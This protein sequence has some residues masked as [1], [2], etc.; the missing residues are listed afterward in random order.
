MPRST[1]GADGPRCP[2]RARHRGEARTIADAYRCG[3]PTAPTTPGG[4]SRRGAHPPLRH[5]G[6][7]RQILAFVTLNA[8][9]L[10][11]AA[12]LLVVL[13]HVMGRR[14]QIGALRAFGAPRAVV[15]AV[16]WLEAVL[17]IGAGLAGG[18]RARL[19]R[20]PNAGAADLDA[21]RRVLPV[22]FAAEDGAAFLLLF[23]IGGLAA[24]LPAMLAYRQSPAAAFAPDARCGA[25]WS[26][27]GDSPRIAWRRAFRPSAAPRWNNARR[28][29]FKIGRLYRECLG[30]EEIWWSQAESNRRPLECI[31]ALSQLSNGPPR[32]PDAWSAGALHLGFSSGLSGPDRSGTGRS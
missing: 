11:A 28:R 14:R 26:G 13:I 15:C 20:R 6:D 18:I 16:V 29:P 9:L 1:G 21:D 27:A 24:L 23:A 30:D 32:A 7:A 2:G 12:V 19:W 31:Q 3:R 10:V 17:V 8:Q 5:V 25:A 4:V 22:G